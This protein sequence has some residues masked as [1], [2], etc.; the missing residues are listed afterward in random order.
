MSQHQEGHIIVQEIV[1]EYPF[2][3][4]CLIQAWNAKQKEYR[5]SQAE[6]LTFSI[7]SM[8]LSLLFQPLIRIVNNPFCVFEGR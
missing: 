6:D 4:S 2:S 5:L 3:L 1:Q 7:A 8:T